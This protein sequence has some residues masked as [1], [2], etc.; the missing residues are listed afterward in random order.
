MDK[1][2]YRKRFKFRGFGITTGKNMSKGRWVRHERV[3]NYILDV[4]KRRETP[5]TTRAVQKSIQD[6]FGVRTS[7]I[8][9]HKY[10][11]QMR[12]AGHVEVIE[13]PGPSNVVKLWQSS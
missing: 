11:D 10:L 6:K 3:N 8:T 1:I 9:V 4:L 2:K 12:R 13:V 7:W 5:A